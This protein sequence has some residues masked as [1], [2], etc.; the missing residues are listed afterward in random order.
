MSITKRGGNSEQ[1]G[2]PAYLKENGYFP[3]TQVS[4]SGRYPQNAV[5]RGEEGNIF[6]EEAHSPI[7][8]RQTEG[9]TIQ[10][11]RRDAILLVLK[12]GVDVSAFEKALVRVVG[13]KAK[14]RSLV[15]K[16]SFEIKDLDET[17][18]RKEIVTAL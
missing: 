2:I 15:S 12:N 6:C 7:I 10:R 16:R 4:V 13:E 17:V 3:E 11:T 18:T 14:I 5:Q 1:A 9:L 8:L